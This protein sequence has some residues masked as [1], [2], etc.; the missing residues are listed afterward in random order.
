VPLD[1]SVLSVARQT[2]LADILLRFN[3]SDD[4]TIT[5]RFK[6]LAVALAARKDPGSFGLGSRTEGDE[7]VRKALSNAPAPPAP[8]ISPGPRSS[9]EVLEVPQAIPVSSCAVYPFSWD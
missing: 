5:Q 2:G 6:R 8:A 4:A 1:V 7:I 9:A 3:P